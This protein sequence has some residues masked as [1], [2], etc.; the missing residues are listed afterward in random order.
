[1]FRF[2]IPLFLLFGGSSFAAE[3]QTNSTYSADSP[4]WVTKGRIDKTTERIQSFMEWDIHR[5]TL[6]WYSSQEKFEQAHKLGP[7]VLAVSRKGDNT[8]LLGPRVNADNFDRIFGHELVHVISYQKYKEAIPKWLEEGLANFV[9]KNG[10]VDYK[11]L[12]NRPFPKDVRELTHPFN[13]NQETLRYHYEASQALAEMISAKCDLRNLLR[14][15]VG[16][17]MESY[18]DTYCNIKDLNSSYQQWIKNKSK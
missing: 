1:M 3:L 11:W 7:S 12:A 14:L 15:S 18:L 4:K 2:F 6:T 5:V 8:V 10:A 17:K 16:Q 13:G 9:A